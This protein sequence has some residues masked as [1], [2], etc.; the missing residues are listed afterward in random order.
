MLLQVLLGERRDF[1][2]LGCSVL[3][4]FGHVGAMYILFRT[5]LKTS[6]LLPFPCC[7]SLRKQAP[8]E[9]AGVPPGFHIPSLPS[10]GTGNP[11]PAL[12]PLCAVWTDGLR[13]SP[14][15][16]LH[17]AD[18][19]IPLLMPWL[20]LVLPTGIH[21]PGLLC[22]ARGSAG[23]RSLGSL[24]EPLNHGFI[25]YLKQ[26]RTWHCLTKSMDKAFASSSSSGLLQ[27]LFGQVILVLEPMPGC[28][29][30]K[31]CQGAFSM[32]TS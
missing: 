26:T 13:A 3:A 24:E 16:L 11:H 14:Q 4:G 10:C 19:D 12:W 31:Q 18:I 27:L 5:G 9:A 1:H 25:S 32:S 17:E 22:A 23:R 6:H 7:C 30:G 20:A 28:A 8:T 29:S 21:T 15:P 2:L